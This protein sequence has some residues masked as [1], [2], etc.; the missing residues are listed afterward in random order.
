MP[1]VVSSQHSRL[2]AADDGF[3]GGIFTVRTAGAKQRQELTPQGLPVDDAHT[4]SSPQ[5]TTELF[6]S[7][8]VRPLSQALTDKEI[9]LQK[10]R[11]VRNP[12]FSL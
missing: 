7:R 5:D 10:E 6:G 12:V 11:L 9:E 3:S 8:G 4:Y 1:V 2:L